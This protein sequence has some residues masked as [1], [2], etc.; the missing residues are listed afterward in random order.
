MKAAPS[1]QEM[2]GR[3]LRMAAIH[4]A[5]HIVVGMH[6]SC[7]GQLNLFRTGT[8]DPVNERQW[9]G[10]V[11]F[12]ASHDDLAAHKEIFLAGSVAE[13]VADDPDV[14]GVE[15]FEW[16][17]MEIIELSA[18]D[19]AGAAGYT[20]DEVIRC[21]DMVKA[22]WADIEQIAGFAIRKARLEE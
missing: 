9:R 12:F 18:T 4:E 15:I 20:E 14:H 17:E 5:A 11:E 19:A 2:E 1:L 7:F 13:C 3:D 8:T 6:F 21:C 10:N 16:L 22:S